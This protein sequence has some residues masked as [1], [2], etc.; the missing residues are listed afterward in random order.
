[1]EATKAGY[2]T[3]IKR[4]LDFVDTLL[5]DKEELGIQC[6]KLV[7]EM[8]AA[9][10]AHVNAMKVAEER[11]SLEIK[12]A[13]DKWAAEEKVIMMIPL[14]SVCAHGFVMMVMEYVCVMASYRLEEKTGSRKR[15]A[16]SRK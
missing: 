8:K 10:K 9:D 14:V 4:Q 11:F 16:P 5:A 6:E 12:R 7:E 2:E 13:R 1:M 15:Y 3:N